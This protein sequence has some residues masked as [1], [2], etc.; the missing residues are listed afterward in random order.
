VNPRC[1]LHLFLVLLVAGGV[2]LLFFLGP[3]GE[4]GRSASQELAFGRGPE[5]DG[6]IARD[7]DDEMITVAALDIEAM[8][9]AV[10]VVLHQDGLSMSTVSAASTVGQVLAEKGIVV[11]SGDY[12]FPSSGSLVT[13]GTHIYIYHARELFLSVGGDT[14]R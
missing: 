5:L 6:N 7:G 1:I 4:K 14:R 3:A 13:A 8:P 11:G 10:P 9:Q 2:S 12:Q